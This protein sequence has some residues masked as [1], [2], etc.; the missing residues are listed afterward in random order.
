MYVRNSD[1]AVSSLHNNIYRA[2]CF[3]WHEIVTVQLQSYQRPLCIERFAFGP[4]F[5]DFTKFFF[6]KFRQFL[7][8]MAEA[9]LVHCLKQ[10]FLFHGLHL[11]AILFIVSHETKSFSQSN[12]TIKFCA[13]SLYDGPRLGF[14]IDKYH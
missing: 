5:R 7:G 13:K 9:G 11:L 3:D 8:V 6:A 2:F 14:R 10:S 4:A 1:G 12:H